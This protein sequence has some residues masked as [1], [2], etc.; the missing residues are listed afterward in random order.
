MNVFG[1]GKAAGKLQQRKAA[2][3]GLTGQEFARHPDVT[4]K[5]SEACQAIKNQISI[6]AISACSQ[7]G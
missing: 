2:I 7:G 5:L 6:R 4:A 1:D 3:T